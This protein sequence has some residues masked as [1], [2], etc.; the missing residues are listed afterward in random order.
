MT[1]WDWDTAHAALKCNFDALLDR[2]IQRAAS[3]EN[4][5]ADATV[6]K[7]LFAAQSQSSL[8]ML[9]VINSRNKA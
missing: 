7:G 8:K 9:K 3:G 5:C 1:E 6:L 4:V 2:T